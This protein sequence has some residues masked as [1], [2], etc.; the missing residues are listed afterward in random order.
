MKSFRSKFSWIVNLSHIKH[1]KSKKIQNFGMKIKI[2]SDEI[3]EFPQ[4]GLLSP[5]FRQWRRYNSFEGGDRLQTGNAAD[6]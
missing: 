1:Q 5:V 4:G 2:R 3:F 6:C